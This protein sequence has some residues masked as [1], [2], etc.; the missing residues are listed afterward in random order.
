[1]QEI[2]I[3]P[4]QILETVDYNQAKYKFNRVLSFIVRKK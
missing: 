4:W 3:K 1:M 2:N